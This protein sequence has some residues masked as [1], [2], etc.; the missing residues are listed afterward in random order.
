MKLHTPSLIA[1]LI[2]CASIAP[3]SGQTLQLHYTYDAQGTPTAD[4]GAGTAA[5]GTLVGTGSTYSTNTPSGTGYAYSST[6]AADAYISAGDVNKIDGLT[7]LT[8]ST[9]IN[10]QTDP[11]ANDRLVSK[12]SGN[13]GFFVAVSDANATAH[14]FGLTF[15]FNGIGTYIAPANLTLSANNTWLFVAFTYDAT[16]TTN[17]LKVYAG[18]SSSAV[19]LLRTDSNAGGVTNGSGTIVGNSVALEIN[20]TPVTAFD[21]SANALYDDT[22]IYDGVLN[23]AALEAI[24]ASEV[25]AVPEPSSYALW[26]GMAAVGAAATLR[27]RRNRTT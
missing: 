4:S 10:F 9:W 13:T 16:S 7:G 6:G 26:F 24:R 3:I 27:P 5:N 23:L 17:N 12:E 2:S 8:F 20:G 11:A 22:R 1:F 21:R 14:T 18:T 19:S 25:S 15:N